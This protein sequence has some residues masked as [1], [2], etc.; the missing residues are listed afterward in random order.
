MSVK[1]MRLLL[2]GH[3]AVRTMTV[4]TQAGKEGITHAVM[5]Q[6]GP[7]THI[8]R[9]ARA[10]AA[11]MGMITEVGGN[12]LTGVMRVVCRV[13]RVTADN[14]VAPVALRHEQGT[15]REAK[16]VAPLGFEEYVAHLQVMDPTRDNEGP[17][18]RD[19]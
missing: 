1:E 2:Y 5:A 10:R 9:L 17:S 16:E 6:S 3:L 14:V 15:D 12:V 11:H 7:A 4:S 13:A 8:I 19:S 18:G